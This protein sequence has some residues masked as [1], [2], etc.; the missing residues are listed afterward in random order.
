VIIFKEMKRSFLILFAAMV[1]VLLFTTVAKIS[2][3][4]MAEPGLS[5]FLYFILL[6]VSII[7]SVTGLFQ[8]IAGKKKLIS[9]I[10]LVCSILVFWLSYR[11][12]TK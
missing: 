12:I 9:L 6:F 2:P 3:A 5:L 4:N 7:S 8:I 10:Y 11:A 1:L